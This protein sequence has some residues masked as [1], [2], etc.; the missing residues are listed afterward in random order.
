MDVKDRI[1]LGSGHVRPAEA[2]RRHAQL[3]RSEQW[4]LW[5]PIRSLRK[6]ASRGSR[7]CF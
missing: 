3:Y 7:L 5:R 6:P 2:E 4:A 1:D